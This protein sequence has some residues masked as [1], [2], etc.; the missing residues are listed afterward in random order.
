MKKFQLFLFLSAYILNIQAQE[1][2]SSSGSSFQNGNLNLSWS[3][4]E[5]MIDTYSQSNGT[6][7]QGFH[8]ASYTI[9][10]INQNL[11]TT[12]I[13][14]VFPNPIINFF[15]V[16]VNHDNCNYELVDVTGAVIKQGSLLNGKTRI[17][18]SYFSKNVYFLRIKSNDKKI[19]EIYKIA[20][21]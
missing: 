7:N 12:Q 6:L 16:E 17:D 13:I 2:V 19:N 3:L 11:E 1:L 10:K 21:N 18:A 8:Q 5:M 15:I 9:T 4:G 20:K 14:K